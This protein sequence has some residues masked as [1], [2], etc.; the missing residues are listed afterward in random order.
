EFARWGSA[1][2]LVANLALGNR[3]LRWLVERLFGLS[4]KRR[5]PR[6]AAPNFLRLAQ[7]R[8]W[9]RKPGRRRPRL[10]YFVDTFATYYDPQVAKAT[11]LVLQHH[12]F[13]VYVPPEQRGSGAPALALGDVEAA[14]ETALANLRVF[15]DLTRE[16]FTVI[17]SE[18]TAALTLRHDYL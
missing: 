9:T 15:S 6:F 7:R 4:Q 11:V 2:G 13:E 1:L 17:C 16:G 18:P 5:L 3:A 12:G 14:R 8:G 10:A